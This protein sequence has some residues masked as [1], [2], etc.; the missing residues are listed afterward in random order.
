MQARAI[1]GVD[2]IQAHGLLRNCDW[3]KPQNNNLINIVETY[4]KLARS[5]SDK[6]YT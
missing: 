4:F 2:G 3:S 5:L 1:L 6:E